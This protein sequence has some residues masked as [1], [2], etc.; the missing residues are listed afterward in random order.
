MVI[1]CVATVAFASPRRRLTSLQ[2]HPTI[3]SACFAAESELCELLFVPSITT[4]LQR[5]LF[6][7]PSS[8]LG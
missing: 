8:A 4:A 3:A 1:D 2:S 5:F 6:I 7:S